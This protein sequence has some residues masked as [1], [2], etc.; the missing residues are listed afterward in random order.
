MVFGDHKPSEWV[1]EKM[2]E[3]EQLRK[4]RRDTKQFKTKVVAAWYLVECEP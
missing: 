1:A 4:V 3:L 2:I